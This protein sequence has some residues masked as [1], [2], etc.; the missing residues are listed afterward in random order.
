MGGAATPLLVRAARPWRASPGRRSGPATDRRRRSACA[1]T[2][3]VYR[4]RCTEPPASR[5]S[6]STAWRIPG[7]AGIGWSVSSGYAPAI[8][9]ATRAGRRR[10]GL[11]RLRRPVA[12]PLRRRRAR[13]RGVH[14]AAL[15]VEDPQ[16]ADGEAMTY[17]FVSPCLRYSAPGERAGMTLVFPTLSGQGWSF[18]KK[19]SF[20]T[21][22]AP[23]VSRPRGARRALSEPDLAVRVCLRRARFV[24]GQLYGGGV[25]A[26][27]LQA[28]M[29]LF[30]AVPGA[31]RDLP[32]RRP[33]RQRRHGQALRDRRRRDDRLHVGAPLGGFLEPVGWVDQRLARSRVGGA[34]RAARLVADAPNSL[35][36]ATPPASGAAIAASVRLRL[37]LPVRGRRGRIRAVHVA[38]VDARSVKFRSVRASR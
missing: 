31:I 5:P 38:V 20:S 15:R 18:I 9:F 3:G 10:R 8:T 28:L 14:G 27:S 36:F 4:A 24:T 16:T 19:P 29:G 13:L 1:L 21:L 6:I 37:P 22:V 12:L 2:G 23:H 32:L 34:R 33:D 35:V 26:Q 7:S 30:L 25:G 17:P 11:R